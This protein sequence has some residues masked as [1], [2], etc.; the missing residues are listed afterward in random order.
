MQGVADA[1][2]DGTPLTW[3]ALRSTLEGWSD[4]TIEAAVGLGYSPD[5]HIGAEKAQI[6]SLTA[7]GTWAV[8]QDFQEL[9][10]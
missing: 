1:T 4:R 2:A 8:S 10:K 6:F 5:R 7:D 3:P 9:P